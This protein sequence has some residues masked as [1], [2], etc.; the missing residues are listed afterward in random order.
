MIDTFGFRKIKWLILVV[1]LLSIFF[2]FLLI[3]TKD[4]E[5][6][7]DIK[8]FVS[9]DTKVLYISNKDEYSSYPVELFNKYE[10]DYLYVDSTKL[11]NIERSKL[12]KF[13][14]SKYL[15]NIIIIYK[16]GNVV[17]AIINYESKNKLN[18]FLQKYN[19]IPNQITDIAG[20]LEKAEATLESDLSVV[21]IPYI[22]DINVESQSDIL[23]SIC[24]EYDINY[25]KID[26]YLLSYKQQE[27]LN[28]LFEISMVDDQI[29]LL[30]KNKT[31]INSFRG[32]YQKSE[33]LDLFYSEKFIN[34][35]EDYTVYINYSNFKDILNDVG[36]NI[37]VIVKD[38][39]KYCDDVVN[40]LNS[41]MINYDLKINYL[42][43][44][45]IDSEISKEVQGDL[46]SLGYSDGFTTPI[47]LIVENNKLL[48]YIIGASNLDYFIDIFKE[49]GIIKEEVKS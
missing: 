8:E 37:I 13:I 27:K 35:L 45:A 44:N 30:V 7:K 40:S 2:V 3:K 32:E 24:E 47:T 21:Y 17:D 9:T 6:I 36:K 33:Y 1:I 19:M 15:N 4:S 12:E 28:A 20:I 39:C 46:L 14:N 48:D 22:Q 49:N 23:S 11:N 42:N 18:L 41:I 34:K 5:I 29:V 31:V 25:E 38:D 26:A 10:I 43:V 16:K